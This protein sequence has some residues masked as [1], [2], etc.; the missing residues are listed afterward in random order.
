MYRIGLATTLLFSC[1]GLA[2]LPSAD[3][4]GSA[5]GGTGGIT[6]STIEGAN[7]SRSVVISE[8]MYHPTLENA[9]VESHE[10]IELYNGFDAAR[11]LAGW[12]LQRVNKDRVVFF[13]FPAGSSLPPKS[14]RVV[15]KDPEKMAAAYKLNRADLWGPYQGELD[16]GG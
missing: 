12:K 14:Y 6:D 4:D 3:A 10:F 15:A 1:T 5:A 13:V 7:A 2:R 11:S 8:L 16:N 9:A